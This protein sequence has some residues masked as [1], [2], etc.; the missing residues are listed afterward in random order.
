MTQHE[1][2]QRAPLHLA[3]I[4]LFDIAG[5]QQLM[6]DENSIGDGNSLREYVQGQ[7]DELFSIS[8]REIGD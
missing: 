1:I 8:F 2:P 6:L 7:C 4:M 5:C 3:F